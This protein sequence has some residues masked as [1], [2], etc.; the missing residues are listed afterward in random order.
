MLSLA[1][2][3]PQ[4]FSME[5]TLAHYAPYSTPELVGDLTPQVCV[6]QLLHIVVC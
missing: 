3:L 6:G 5:E 1:L 4:P 2:C